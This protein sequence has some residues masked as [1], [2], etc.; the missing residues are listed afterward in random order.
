MLDMT[1]SHRE[2]DDTAL[3]RL[4]RDGSTLAFA[5]LT[6]RH[7]PRLTA[8]AMRMLRNPA[9]AQDVVQDAFVAAWRKLHTFREEASF[10]SWVYR[11][12]TN[13]CLMKLRSKR[14]RP[15]VPLYDA[16]GD[17]ERPVLDP[18]K[19]AS[20]RHLDRELGSAIEAAMDTLPDGYRTVFVLADLE[21][22]SMRE[23]A[24]VLNLSVPNTKTRLHRARLRL[25]DALAPYLA[26]EPVARD[27]EGETR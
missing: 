1:A 7:T 15:E 4:S 14:R 8:L 25:R 17:W 13:G 16:E 20:E 5:E 9:D 18:S 24:L 27:T 19:G 3:V 2:L 23:I 10:G 21:H 12:T 26:A 22:R 6:H 11:I